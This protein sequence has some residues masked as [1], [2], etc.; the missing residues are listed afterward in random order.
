MAG[1]RHSAAA[2]VPVSG[3]RM[4]VVSREKKRE[5]EKLRGGGGGTERGKGIF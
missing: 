3:S 1:E 2:G 4:K 5:R